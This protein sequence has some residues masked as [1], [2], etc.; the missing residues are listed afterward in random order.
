MRKIFSAIIL[1]LTA[2]LFLPPMAPARD[3][4]QK[5]AENQII[6]AVNLYND[7]KFKDA[8]SVLQEV[9]EFLKEVCRKLLQ[10]VYFY[11]KDCQ[12]YGISHPLCAS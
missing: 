11:L 2:T 5:F 3:Y 9:L 10:S 12:M 6:T 1:S 7:G 4:K 8:V